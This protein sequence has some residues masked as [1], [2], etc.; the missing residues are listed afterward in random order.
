MTIARHRLIVAA[1]CLALMLLD[2]PEVRAESP[3]ETLRDFF[4]EVNQILAEPE[5]KGQPTERLIAFRKR[6]N[7]AFDYREAAELALGREWQARTPAEQEEFV[8]LFADLLERS[9]VLQVAAKA[10][11]NAG[12]RVRFLGE[13]VNRDAATVR[14]ALGSRDGGEILLDYQMT[15][16]GERWAIRDVVLEGVSLV[17]NYRAQFHRV[18]RGWSYPELVARMK[19]KTAGPRHVSTVPAETASIDPAMPRPPRIEDDP[20]IALSPRRPDS[21]QHEAAEGA[22]AG[23]EPAPSAAG[24]TPVTATSYWVQVGAFRNPDAVG[25]LASRLREQ[26]LALSH[27]PE[28]LLRVRVGPFSDRAEALSKL[29]D[30]R[31]KGYKPFIVEEVE[32]LTAGR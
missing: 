23:V 26:N 20:P 14:T 12:V 19:A 8:Q 7:H 25:R 10:G 9:Y 24:T 5:I 1:A 17:A 18:I 11:L 2:R 21:G 22:R 13:S 4:A 29:I 3:T 28:L 15:K 6:V 31:A 30:L 16:L 27:G 32:K